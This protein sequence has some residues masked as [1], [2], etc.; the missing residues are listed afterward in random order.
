M[1]RIPG[2]VLGR[3]SR[4]CGVIICKA[5]VGRR[6]ADR[7]LPLLLATKERR[8]GLAHRARVLGPASRLGRWSRG[9]KVGVVGARVGVGIG[10]GQVK[11]ATMRCR[12][13]RCRID[14]VESRGCV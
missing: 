9:V 11:V 6:R 1:G 4:H 5:Q 2:V 3:L 10:D 12:W 7:V 13:Q 14:C 8:E